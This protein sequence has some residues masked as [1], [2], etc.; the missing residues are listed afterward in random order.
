M[1]V[2]NLKDLRKILEKK[3]EDSLEK[4]VTNTIRDVMLENIEETVY[5]TYEPFQ[6]DRRHEKEGLS[7][8]SNIGGVI[9]NGELQVFNATAGNSYI[10]NNGNYSISQ[11]TGQ[12]LAPI[13]E[14][15]QGYDFS[16]ENGDKGYEKPRPFVENT[17][18]ELKQ[19][20]EHVKALKRGLKNRGIN[21]E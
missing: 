18:E 15:G 14:Y 12:Y 19:T 6:Y 8:P 20:K 9:V 4:E 5:D 3:I 16:S 10:S 1:T 21:V 7:D 2:N 11:N 17:R 13:I